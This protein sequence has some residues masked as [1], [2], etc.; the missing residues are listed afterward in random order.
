MFVLLTSVSNK[1]YRVT[2]HLFMQQS[3]LRTFCMINN[4]QRDLTEFYRTSI[5]L[6]S[7]NSVLDMYAL[8]YAQEFQRHED[9]Q[10]SALCV[11]LLSLYKKQTILICQMKRKHM[12]MTKLLHMKFVKEFVYIY[13][14]YQIHVFMKVHFKT[15]QIYGHI[16][17]FSTLVILIENQKESR[18]GAKCLI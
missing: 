5:K 9:A 16:S 18:V 3:L 13:C 10:T 15:A 7:S 4:L 11:N 17:K 14:Y 1:S 6:N 8:K 12:C 2:V